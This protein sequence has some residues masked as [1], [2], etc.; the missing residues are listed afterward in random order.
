MCV[1]GGGGGRGGRVIDQHG[2]EI[3]P[4]FKETF[5]PLPPPTSTPFIFLLI[6]KY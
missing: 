1:W 4:F 6:L 3:S 5:F 2:V